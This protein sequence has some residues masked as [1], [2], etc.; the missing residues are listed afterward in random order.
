MRGVHGVRLREEFE[1]CD[2]RS[3]ESVLENH[4]P[5]ETTAPICGRARQVRRR[6]ANQDR[7]TELVDRIGEIAAAFRVGRHTHVALPARYQ[8]A[9][10]LLT[11]EEK[12]FVLARV[13]FPGYVNRSAESKAE[14]LIMIPALRQTDAVIGPAVGVHSFVSI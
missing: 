11:P 9:L 6:I 2:A 12:Q 5:R 10:P 4:I 7:L 8:L 13:E 14:V 3:I 1:Q